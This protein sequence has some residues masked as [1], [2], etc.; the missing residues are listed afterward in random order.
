[1]T[2]NKTSNYTPIWQKKKKNNKSNTT[3]ALLKLG[4]KI[5]V[6]QAS[7]GYVPERHNGKLRWYYLLV[8]D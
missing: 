8:W 4:D 7:K 1:M 3:I 2:Y 5:I 6:M